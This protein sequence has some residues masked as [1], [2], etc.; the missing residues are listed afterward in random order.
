MTI[1]SSDDDSHLN[2]IVS[3][4]ELFE[5]VVKEV[6]TVWETQDPEFV[7]IIRKLRTCK[8]KSVQATSSRFK[9]ITIRTQE[10]EG[11]ILLYFIKYVLS[12]PYCILVSFFKA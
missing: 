10:T 9:M 5:T 1:I 2:W 6:R 12:K 4:G 3:K 11:V 8:G 7:E